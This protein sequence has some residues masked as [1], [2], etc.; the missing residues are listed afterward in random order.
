MLQELKNTEATS[1]LEDRRRS[2]KGSQG[3]RERRQ[4]RDGA[5]SNRPEVAELADAIDR[6][7]MQNRRRFI[8]FEE[9]YDVVLELGY[10]R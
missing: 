5:R 6:Y 9:L 1:G 10:H 3:G 2:D 8:T 7:K 4:F